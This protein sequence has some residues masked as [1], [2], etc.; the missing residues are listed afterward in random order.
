VQCPLGW[1]AQI[2]D[3][4]GTIVLTI[5]FASLLFD[6]NS[7]PVRYPRDAAT[8]ALEPAKATFASVR[9]S[10]S[11]I[12]EGITQLKAQLQILARFNA[13]IRTRST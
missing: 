6:S 10:Y 13:A 4:E 12:N 7:P 11:E 3:D 9:Q 5:K 8:D 1:R 2:A